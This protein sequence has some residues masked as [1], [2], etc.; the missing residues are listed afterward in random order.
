MEQFAGTLEMIPLGV[1]GRQPEV[2]ACCGLEGT[3]AAFLGRDE[4]DTVG[5]V[6]AVE[7]CGG[8][9]GEKLDV[10][11]VLHGYVGE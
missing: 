11:D 6:G 9:A 4:D 5:C 3:V 7:C 1:G 10:V 2:Y 8:T